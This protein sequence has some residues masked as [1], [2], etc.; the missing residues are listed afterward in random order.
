MGLENDTFSP[1][2]LEPYLTCPQPGVSGALES[3]VK[4]VGLGFGSWNRRRLRAPTPRR[5]AVQQRSLG[6]PTP[7]A[8]NRAMG[9][10]AV[11][12]VSATWTMRSKR[13]IRAMPRPGRLREDSR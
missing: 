12:F 7:K 3:C 2:N 9:R 13:R 4:R 5:P 10:L 6:L 11:R 8:H 1:R